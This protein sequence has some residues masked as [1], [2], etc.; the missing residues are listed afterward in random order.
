LSSGFLFILL[1]ASSTIRPSQTQTQS[2]VSQ[3]ASPTH[4][5]ANGF[6]NSADKSCKATI[7]QKMAADSTKAIHK[8]AKV[9][10]KGVIFGFL[11][12]IIIILFI[13]KACQNA[14]HK[15]ASQI[16][17]LAHIES[18]SLVISFLIKINK[19]SPGSINIFL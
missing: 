13:K 4:I 7:S 17:K 8:I 12:R 16:H 14:T 18:N 6:T 9:K 1:E 19:L 15:A 11:H 5:E 3:I 10:K 2:Q